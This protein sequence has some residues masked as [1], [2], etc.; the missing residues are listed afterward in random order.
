MILTTGVRVSAEFQLT[1]GIHQLTISHS[2]CVVLLLIE[3]VRTEELLRLLFSNYLGIRK[4]QKKD[5]C[6]CSVCTYV[7]AV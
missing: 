3:T 4:S 1:K 7:P 2:A 6:N 5:V